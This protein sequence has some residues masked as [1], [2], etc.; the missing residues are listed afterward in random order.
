MSN[1][2]I[3]YPYSQGCT[4]ADPYIDGETLV[5]ELIFTYRCSADCESCHLMVKNKNAMKPETALRIAQESVE[6]AKENGFNKVCFYLI[7][8]EAFEALDRLQE[9]YS[10]LREKTYDIPILV[11]IVTCGKS[12]SQEGYQWLKDNPEVSLALK[13]DSSTKDLVWDKAPQCFKNAVDIVYLTVNSKEIYKLKENFAFLSTLSIPVIADYSTLDR[14]CRADLEQFLLQLYICAKIFNPLY[15]LIFLPDFDSCTDCSKGNI[16][17]INFNGRKYLCKYLSPG[18]QLSRI[19]SEEP[20]KGTP[21]ECADCRAKDICKLCPA[22]KAVMNNNYCEL[23][24]TI[25]IST[26]KCLD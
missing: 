18:Y 16:E 14:L 2:M 11:R 23:M 21:A 26:N 20:P 4:L 15:K 13:W 19:Y 22:A 1:K 12:I 17:S 7:G 8:G 5:R 6:Y 25:V 24:R 3:S 10:S 9:F